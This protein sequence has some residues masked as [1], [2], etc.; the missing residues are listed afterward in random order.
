[1]MVAEVLVV[2]LIKVVVAVEV[3][4]RLDSIHQ[5]QEEGGDWVV[6]V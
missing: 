1:M 2:V 5:A 6:T 3:L 4:V